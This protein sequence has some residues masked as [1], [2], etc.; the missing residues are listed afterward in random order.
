MNRSSAEAYQLLHRGALAMA[1]LEC[2]GMAVDMEYL[3]SAVAKT[4]RQLD[5]ME[6][7]LKQTK[8]WHAW[9]QMAGAKANITSY[10]QIGKLLFSVLGHRPHGY[11]RTGRYSANEAAVESVDRPFC[12]NWLRFQKKQKALSTYLVGLQREVVDGFV[13][14]HL[15]LHN[16]TTYRGSCSAPNLHNQPKR[17][18]KIKALVRPCFIPRAPDRHI[19]EIDFSGAEVRT[20]AC[21]NRDPVLA[22]YIKDKT[23][24]MHRDMAAQI[25]MCRPDQVDGVLRHCGKNKYVFASFYGSYYKQTA[26]DFWH[27]AIRLGGAVGKAG[28]PF[29]EWMAKRGITELG[30]VDHETDP[31]PGTFVAHVRDVERDFWGRRFRVY[32]EWKKSWYND[33]LRTGGFRTLTG[34]YFNGVLARNDVINYPV[35]GT[36]FHLLL[37]CLTELN[38]WLKRNKMRTVI[39]THIHDSIVLDAHPDEL[40]RVLSK[41]AWLMTV[42]VRKHWKWICVPL[43]AEVEVS[44]QGKSWHHVEPWEKRNGK[45]RPAQQTA[46]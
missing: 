41:A 22:S 17:N 43:E 37:W 6:A 15:P 33:Y 11:T 19:V 44:P 18:K 40:Q 28:V 39:I 12:R 8:E 25:C 10:P 38:A 35:Q 14:P 45:W 2:N 20:A 27:E 26:P 16:V 29:L 42:G 3:E 7:K 36:S 46:R 21:Y 32:A 4:R 5:R 34:F 23:R 31:E 30:E 24:D 13:Y 9:Q 1:D